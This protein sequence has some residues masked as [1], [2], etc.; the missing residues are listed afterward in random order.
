MPDPL[1]WF[2]IVILHATVCPGKCVDTPA[3]EIQ[4]PSE[5][6]CKQVKQDNPD[7][8]LDCWAKPKP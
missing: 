8:P 3:A 1:V 7:V 2:L 6:V 4:M 5:A